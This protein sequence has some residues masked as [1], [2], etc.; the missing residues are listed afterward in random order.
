[1]VFEFVAGPRTRNPQ[2]CRPHLRYCI[3]HEDIWSFALGLNCVKSGVSEVSVHE[4]PV[5]LSLEYMMTVH[6]LGILTDEAQSF[7]TP[8]ADSCAVV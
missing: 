7:G 8:F 6:P 2:P 4:V 1:M 3:L 5:K